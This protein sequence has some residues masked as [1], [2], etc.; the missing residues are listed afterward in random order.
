MKLNF[1]GCKMLNEQEKKELEIKL[2]TFYQEKEKMDK[3]IADKN[4]NETTLL[5]IDVRG[6]F[7]EI[8][9]LL[10]EIHKILKREDLKND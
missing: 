10:K 1:W 4:L 3:E 5:L 6:L 2:K 8:S 7:W 9:D